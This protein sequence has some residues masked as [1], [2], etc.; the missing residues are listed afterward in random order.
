MPQN[1]GLMPTPAIQSG[2]NSID[3]AV[4]TALPQAIPAASVNPLQIWLAVLSLIW[5]SGVMALLIYSIIS[6]VKIKRKL[7]TATRVE[8]NVYATEAIGT[9]FVCG[10]IRPRIYVPVHVAEADLSYILEHER[11]CIR[12]RDYYL[13]K[14]LAFLALSL[15][16]FNPLMWLSFA[17]MSRDMEMAC[18][19]SVLRRLGDSVKGGYSGSLL[20][21]SQRKGLL[22]VNPLAF[23]ESH[24]KARIKNV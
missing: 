5:I 8:G 24:V 2:L 9:A 16:W 1:I 17:L 22:T 12:R 21:L 4:N 7:Q 11:S 6:Y 15:H 20:S 18:D 10:F 14:P 3:N 23:G 13:I 19:D